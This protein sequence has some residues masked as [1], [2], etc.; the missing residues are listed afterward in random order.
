MAKAGIR[1][2]RAQEESLRHQGVEMVLGGMTHVDVAEELGVHPHSIDRW[3]AT[4]RAKGKEGLL[5]SGREGR[6]S[7]LSEDQKERLK[8]ILANGPAPYGYE[9]GLWTL[10]RIAKV[11]D[12]EFG[13]SY[14]ESHV[15]RLLQGIGWSCQRPTKRAVERDEQKIAEWKKKTWPALKKTPKRKAKP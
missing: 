10:P 9:I 12:Q 2:D 7:L 15:W 1:T 14:H 4:Y 11:I 13:I 6:P 3:M 8:K 5:W